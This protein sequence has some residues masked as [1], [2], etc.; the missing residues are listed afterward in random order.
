MHILLKGLV[1]SEVRI[2]RRMEFNIAKL[3]KTKNIKG[4]RHLLSLPV[5]GQRTRTNA[6]TQRLKRAK[7][8]II[9]NRRGRRRG[10]R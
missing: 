1:V 10:R 2:K 4:L 5:H 6:C 3:T 7:R 8:V 9:S